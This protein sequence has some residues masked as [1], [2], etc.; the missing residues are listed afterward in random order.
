MSACR[1]PEASPEAERDFLSH[2]LT[3]READAARSVLAG[4]TAEQAGSSLG[5]S[6]STVGNLRRSAYRKLDV[7]D[8]RE[9][10]AR[11]APSAG[12][13][14]G[15]VADARG[16]LLAHGLSETQADVLARVAAGRSSAEIASELHVAPGTVSAARANGYRV[17]GVHS[18]EELVELIESDRTAPRKRRG[19]LL[20][21]ACVVATLSVSTGI[22]VW[23]LAGSTAKA[24]H[25]PPAE[26]D[27]TLVS[28][29]TPVPY[30]SD[31][32]SVE[33]IQEFFSDAASVTINRKGSVDDECCLVVESLSDGDP[34]VGGDALY[35]GANITVTVTSDT[36]M[37]DVLGLD[38][39]RV[40]SALR[41]AGLVPSPS[42]TSFQ[43]TDGSPLVPPS[44]ES[45]SLDPLESARVGTVVTL[46]YDSSLEGYS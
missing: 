25:T 35:R 18:R 2:G 23:Q 5:I 14:A 10:R 37:P 39:I 17:L 45:A 26:T 28:P 30:P 19:R 33:D 44:M 46:T 34:S 36:R 4:M 6:A 12:G 21:A 3:E 29:L 16:A 42:L 32:T 1:I 38:P 20:A 41:E 40:T 13:S 24:A 27:N 22:A 15:G 8:G 31:V 7:A 43:R 11:Y 9:L